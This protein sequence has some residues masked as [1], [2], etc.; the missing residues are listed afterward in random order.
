MLERIA[1]DHQIIVTI[2][3]GALKGGFGN[4][5]AER[6]AEKKLMHIELASIGIADNF[7]EQGAPDILY[8]ELGMSA[9]GICKAVR[10]CAGYEIVRAGHLK[11]FYKHS[12]AS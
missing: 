5:I 4:E 7:V 2:E 10:D 6:L 12:R 8:K 3:D 9:E 1:R 11:T